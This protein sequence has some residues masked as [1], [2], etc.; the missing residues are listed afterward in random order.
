MLSPQC[1]ASKASTIHLRF[2]QIVLVVA[3]CVLEKYENLH[4]SFVQQLLAASD[5]EGAAVIKVSAVHYSSTF[6]RCG[7]ILILFS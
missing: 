4:G 2:L 7:I 1:P 3:K 5:D 6:Q